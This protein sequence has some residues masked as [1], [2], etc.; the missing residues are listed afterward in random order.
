MS[1]GFAVGFGLG[2]I[3]GGASMLGIAV[4]KK[5]SEAASKNSNIT[6]MRRL[7]WAAVGII[8]L[9]SGVGLAYY[10]TYVASE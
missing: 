5:L 7:L 3:G 6:P 8:L 2:L 4:S 1:N 10:G 9:G